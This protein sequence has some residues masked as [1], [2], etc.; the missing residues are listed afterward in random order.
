MSGSYSSNYVS[1][2][3]AALEASR[4][5]R[6]A[7]IPTRQRLAEEERAVRIADL[8]RQLAEGTLVRRLATDEERR[9]FGIVAPAGE[10]PPLPVA[11][12]RRPKS[13]PDRGVW[14]GSVRSVARRFGGFVRRG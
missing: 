14:S 8:E 3:L 12:V 13:Q 2:K 10:L 5:S 1:P 11:V 6:P 9:R 4:G 7:K